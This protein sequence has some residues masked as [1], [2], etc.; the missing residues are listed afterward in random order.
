MK[1]VLIA[2]GLCG[3]TMLIAAENI[4]E[5]CRKARIPV[6]VDIKNLWESASTGEGY[7]VIVEMFPYFENVS[8]PLLSGKPFINRL[9]GADKAL[10]AQ[11]VELLR[12]ER[13]VAV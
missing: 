3:A 2:G 7:D 11:I 10:V 12:D 5:S 1:K 6:H 13:K 9:G 4:E 8:C